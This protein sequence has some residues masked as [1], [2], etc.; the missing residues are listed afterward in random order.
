MLWV[1]LGAPQ[2][3]HMF[4]WR[5]KKNISTLWLK[6][7]ALAGAMKCVMILMVITSES[8]PALEAHLDAHPTGN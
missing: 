8:P 1:L 5:N 2:E 4:L 3:E 7:S 6:K